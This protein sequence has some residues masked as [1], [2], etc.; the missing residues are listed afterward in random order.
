MNNKLN[1]NK[2]L[3][4]VHREKII[5][6][7]VLCLFV[8]SIFGSFVLFENINSSLA[9]VEPKFVYTTENIVNSNLLTASSSV[10]QMVTSTY[11]VA[12]MLD[13]NSLA[14]PQSGLALAD[15]IYE[16]PV[17][18]GATR[19]MAIMNLNKTE[20]E[21]GPVRSARPYFVNWAAEFDA[22]YVHAGG[23]PEAL[24]LIGSSPVKDLNEISGYGPVYFYRN[25]QKLAPHNLYTNTE[26][27]RQALVDFK[28][29]QIERGV[30]DN[31]IYSQSV[32]NIVV[33]STEVVVDFSE[34]LV[35]D[36]RFVYSLDKKIYYRYD[37][38]LTKIDFATKLP[39]EISNIIIQL[40]PP[41]IVLDNLG[42]LSLT[43]TGKGNGY[44][45]QAGSKQE[46]TWHK[47]SGFSPTKFFNQ[48]KEIELLPGVTWILIVPTDREV[49]FE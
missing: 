38:N 15:F 25:K 29:D 43:I 16:A 19:L 32:P 36:A 9:K 33:T 21:I 1:K 22:L 11:P 17:E 23:S 7:I 48:S 3:F 4:F 8:W 18:G 46:I 37:N 12:I 26:N 30:Y 34:G 45:L 5:A 44:L 14:R 24:S 39:I 49:F 27:L 42:R 35:Y 10:A 47:E 13:N 20:V 28:L 41:E 40:I 31:F 2:D 6:V